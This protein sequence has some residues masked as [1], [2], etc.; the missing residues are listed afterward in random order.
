VFDADG[1]PLYLDSAHLTRSYAMR[2]S[3]YID[4]TLDPSASRTEGRVP[5]TRASTLSGK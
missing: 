5:V 2:A 1:R 4:A 3:T